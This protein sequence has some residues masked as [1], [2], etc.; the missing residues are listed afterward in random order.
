[1][2]ATDGRVLPDASVVAQKL[3]VE[4]RLIPA[5]S[6]PIGSGEVRPRDETD[7]PTF[8]LIW[9]VHV[10]AL[11][12]G[13]IYRAN[14]NSNEILAVDS[15]GLVRR[16]S[17]GNKQ[18][19]GIEI[20]RWTIDRLLLGETVLQEDINA[21]YIGRASA[22]VVLVLSSLPLFETVSVGGKQALRM[23]QPSRPAAR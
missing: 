12:G 14:G 23:R 18:R 7:G 2:I 13:T 22:G 21:H 16:T 19:I 5:I 17:K 11:E 3:D 8:D 6:S 1:M 10:A 15:G 20:F 4:I 9:S